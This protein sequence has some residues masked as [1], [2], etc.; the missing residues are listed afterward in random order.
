MLPYVLTSVVHLIVDMV[1]GE[2][3]VQTS[4]ELAFIRNGSLTSYG[5]DAD[6]LQDHVMPFMMSVEEHGI[7]MQDNARQHS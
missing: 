4:T 2:T 6:I 1:W 5:Y 7:F 3:T